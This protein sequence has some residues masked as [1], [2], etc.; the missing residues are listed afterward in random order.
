MSVRVTDYDS[1]ADRFDRRY[2]LHSYSGVRE[3]LLDFIG[4]ECAE[5][6]LE[7]GCG[8]GHWLRA[9]SG[10]ALMIAGIDPSAGMLAR[11]RAT[12]PGA[13]LIR[14]SADSLPWRDASFDR[15]FCINALHHFPDRG[16]FLAEAR[17]V[18][19][20]GG[21]FLTVSKD[22][23]AE[24]DDWW[25]YDYFPETLA[26]DR[27]R[28]APVRTLRGEMSLAGFA[29]A[30][31]SEADRIEAVTHASEAF[32]SGLVDRAYT[33][34]LTVLTDEEFD[35]GVARLRE[36]Q[37]EAAASGGALDLVTD[38]RLYATTGWLASRV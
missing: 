12:A 8:T 31:S 3:T 38:F 27:Q 20:P 22:P 16:R 9:M 28:F 36:A 29:W 33:S 10:R 25:V 7:V 15:V 37:A 4:S 23:H 34:Q 1:V 35:S 5:A 2:V 17:R 21:G 18:L 26:I 14:A 19:R 24:R 30:E 11:A 13:H 6:V 32:D